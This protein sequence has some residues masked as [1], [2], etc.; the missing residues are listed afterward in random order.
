[1]YKTPK[2]LFA[3]AHLKS[4]AFLTGNVFRIM[5][6]L[7]YPRIHWVQP[8]EYKE[9]EGG[10]RNDV[11]CKNS[12]STCKYANLRCCYL[13]SLI[14][15]VLFVADYSVQQ[16]YESLRLWFVWLSS[17]SNK[18]REHS[19][20]SILTRNAIGWYWVSDSSNDMVFLIS[21]FLLWYPWDL[22]WCDSL[23]Q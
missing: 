16:W 22:T 13:E 23:I 4:V 18:L 12:Q 10:E 9:E 7:I 2:C 3:I 1:M 20:M 15:V 19:A 14:L 5:R 11:T 6:V 21:A 17:R 8:T